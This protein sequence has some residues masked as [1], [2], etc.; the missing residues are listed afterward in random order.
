M[1]R[2]RRRR[3]DGFSTTD[4]ASPNREASGDENIPVH[5]SADRNTR[6]R[7]K[8]SN[9]G[10]RERGSSFIAVKHARLQQEAAVA[11]DRPDRPDD[12]SMA[13][14]LQVRTPAKSTAR[15]CMQDL[16][17]IWD[18]D[19][20]L[21]SSQTLIRVHGPSSSLARLENLAP[22]WLIQSSP[23]AVPQVLSA[24]ARKSEH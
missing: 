18:M 23:E 16:G 11:D 21:T 7:L 12:P 15:S 9:G 17:I 5:P 22:Q 14:M 3:Q 10:V 4:Q 24:D 1:Q 20:A 8:S 19:F 6:V 13:A 2:G